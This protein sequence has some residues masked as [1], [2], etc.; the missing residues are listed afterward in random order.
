MNV[1]SDNGRDLVKL[2]AFFTEHMAL[3]GFITTYA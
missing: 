3:D 2:R 1:M